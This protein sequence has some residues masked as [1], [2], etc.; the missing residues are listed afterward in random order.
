M[1]TRPELIRQ[2]AHHVADL[3]AEREPSKP[4]PAIHVVA[5]VSLNGRKPQHMIDDDVDLAAEPATLGTPTWVVPLRAP[6]PPRDEVWE[7]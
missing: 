1:K 7:P 3:A 6:L 5:W 2:Y 4:R